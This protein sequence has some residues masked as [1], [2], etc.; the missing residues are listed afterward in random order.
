MTILRRIKSCWID[1]NQD[2]EDLLL[3][4]RN[5]D[6]EYLLFLPDRVGLTGQFLLCI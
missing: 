3:I 5:Q 1:R 4:C 2:T 6:A